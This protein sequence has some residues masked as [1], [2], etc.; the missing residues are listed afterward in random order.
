MSH[1]FENG[2]IIQFT[3]KAFVYIN[4]LSSLLNV[5]NKKSVFPF[6][7]NTYFR[8]FILILPICV[9][10]QTKEFL[11]IKVACV[12]WWKTGNVW[13]GKGLKA[14]KLSFDVVGEN[15]KYYPIHGSF[16]IYLNIWC[17]NKSFS[18]NSVVSST[19]TTKCLNVKW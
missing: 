4:L 13:V 1:S 8:A 7:W 9:G 2:T 6:T 11:G 5:N 12:T 18:S 10:C 19:T 14:H 15:F 16:L 17:W 3:I